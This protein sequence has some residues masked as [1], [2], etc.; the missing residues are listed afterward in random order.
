MFARVRL[1]SSKNLSMGRIRPGGVV[2]TLPFV[3]LGA[4]VVSD[5]SFV[6][7]V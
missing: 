2:Q 3:H 5:Q 1:T 7:A 6:T 4:Q